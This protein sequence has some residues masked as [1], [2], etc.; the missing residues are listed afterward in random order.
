MAGSPEDQQRSPS[1]QTEVDQAKA[2][3]NTRNVENGFARLHEKPHHAVGFWDPSMRKVR[4]H[5][6]RLWLQTIAILFAFILAVLS[7]YWAV[8]F[9]TEANLR[10]V[11]VHVVNFDG[12]VAPYESIQ[13]IVGPTVIQTIQ[14]TL[15]S[16]GPS[17]GWTILQPSDFN[18][19][20]T[21]VRMAV[22]DF[23]SWAAVIVHAN[24]TAALQE[25][26]ATGDAN[27]DPAGSL[28]IITQTARD[29]TTY[30]SDIQPYLTQ[31]T[32]QFSQA[33]G[34]QWGQIVMSNDSLSR[35]NLARAPAVVNPGVAPLMIDI[36]PFR[37]AT[38]TPAVS[39]GLIYLI[40]MAFFSFS[41]FL[42]I[43]MVC[44]CP[45]SNGY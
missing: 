38:A 33:F 21:A 12:Q 15:D 30:Q 24:A 8:L 36:R 20:P 27:Y 11:V 7:L 10:S 2:D 18:N 28:Q 44:A 43:H 1:S 45:V 23:K 32:E 14:K 34:K 9:R 3:E 40:I 25:A 17:L 39:I 29:S 22:Y 31:F 13:P 19:D 4:A 35:E 37:P 41:F 16:P 26:A 6:I 5:V 42:P